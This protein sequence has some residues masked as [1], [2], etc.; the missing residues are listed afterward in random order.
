MSNA[1]NQAYEPRLS[2]LMGLML[3]AVCANRFLVSHYFLVSNQYRAE[4][5]DES[6][7]IVLRYTREAVH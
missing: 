7:E 1:D 2:D 5:L 6:P 4:I 3:M